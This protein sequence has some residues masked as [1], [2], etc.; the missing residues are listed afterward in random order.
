VAFIV[1]NKCCNN[2]NKII[3]PNQNKNEEKKKKL[4]SKN[5][6]IIII[7]SKS[8]EVE[9][10]VKEN[11]VAEE[12]SIHEDENVEQVKKNVDENSNVFNKID[13]DK[14]IDSNNQN[15][16]VDESME[17]QKIEEKLKNFSE[18]ED[19][20]KIMKEKSEINNENQKIS[21][22]NVS[23]PN[24]QSPSPSD[25][26]ANP[27]HSPTPTYPTT[28]NTSSESA[29]CNSK[30]LSVAAN[31]NTSPFNSQSNSNYPI[32]L[33]TGVLGSTPLHILSSFQVLPKF[34]DLSFNFI[35]SFRW[36]KDMDEYVQIRELEYVS[37]LNEIPSPIGCL[38]SQNFKYFDQFRSTFSHTVS[39]V[40]SQ[41]SPPSLTIS[42][43]HF[44]SALPPTVQGTLVRCLSSSTN[45]VNGIP[46]SKYGSVNLF[47]KEFNR[48]V[49]RRRN[50]VGENTQSVINGT[51]PNNGVKLNNL[52]SR[53]ENKDKL[54]LFEEYE[55]NDDE[56]EA[57]INDNIDDYFIID[58]CSR[59]QKNSLLIQVPV[60]PPPI[61]PAT[62]TRM[63][64]SHHSLHNN[65]SQAICDICF[66][67]R[68]KGLF[69]SKKSSLLSSLFSQQTLP[70]V[71]SQLNNNN[72]NLPKQ[73]EPSSSSDVVLKTETKTT[74][75]EIESQIK[76]ST[77]LNIVDEKPEPPTPPPPYLS[78]LSIP[79]SNDGNNPSSYTRTPFVERVT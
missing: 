28:Q 13:D 43:L 23:N 55:I 36:G 71:N 54:D 8:E 22:E 77:D 59:L 32:F 74:E 46:W 40:P 48:R 79:K 41:Y 75:E 38:H 6:S 72:N 47:E 9:K 34:F 76:L 2:N 3:K 27:T 35:G 56:E 14:K 21:E 78:D 70:I 58:S 68:R 10:K 24:K 31:N 66:P 15:K 61:T 62:Y 52:I 49:Q 57:V 4:N 39:S 30:L 26:T 1:E 20:E 7:N 11:N 63:I 53:D 44:L 16:N 45:P 29:S 25:L 73:S 69:S 17:E 12:K 5:S 18:T 60:A 37:S 67:Q 51:P 64:S 65:Y 33:P 42:S 19:S 50:Y